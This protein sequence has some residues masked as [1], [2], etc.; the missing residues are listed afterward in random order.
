MP[1]ESM[2]SALERW[3]DEQTRTSRRAFIGRAGSAG[4]ALSGLSAVLAACGGVSGTD[5]N[6]VDLNATGNHPKTKITTLDFSNWPLYIDKSVLKTWDKQTGGHVNYI[7]DINDNNDFFGKVRQQLI[8]GQPIGRD[9]VALTTYMAAKWVRNGYTEAIDKRNVPNAKNLTPQL[10]H[11]KY[12]PNRNYTLPWQTG[13]TGIGYNIKETGREIRST[14]ELFSPE[15]KGRVT[16]LS[17]PY[18]SAGLVLAMQGKN[19]TDATIDQ[20]LGAIDFIGQAQQKGQFRRFTGNDYTTDLTKGNVAI[21]MAY[22]GDMVQLQSDNPNMRFSYPEEGAMQFEDDMM[23]PEKAAHPYAAENMMNFVYEPE[24]AA[25]IA[26][27]VNYISPVDGVKEV[28]LKTDPKLANDP[29]LF[30]GEA[31]RKRMYPYP[32]FTDAE[33][34][35]MYAAMAQVTGS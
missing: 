26:A 21:A 10:R 19:P 14:K 8:Q 35:K 33:E 17:E 6:K 7:E 25:K 30:P 31:I 20:Q 18:D 24:I 28:L 11:P 3:L 32:T 27:Y 23:I 16:A 4:L 12:D 22:G 34:R 2:E 9:L 29:L 1:R 15:W 5:T 13:P